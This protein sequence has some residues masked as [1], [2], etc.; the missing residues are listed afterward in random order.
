MGG[1]ALDA[2]CVRDAEQSGD[3]PPHSIGEVK[4]LSRWTREITRTST[5]PTET[6]RIPFA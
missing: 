2:I 5:P 4:V 3:E 1:A 6:V